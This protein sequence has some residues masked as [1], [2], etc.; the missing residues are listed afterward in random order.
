[1]RGTELVLW[2]PPKPSFRDGIRGAGHRDTG[3]THQAR[4]GLY[5]GGR[6][7]GGVGPLPK[8]LT[9]TCSKSDLSPGPLFNIAL[10]EREG[11]PTGRAAGLLGG[12]AGAA[13]SPV[14]G[15]ARVAGFAGF[16][17]TAAGSVLWLLS[18]SERPSGDPPTP[19]APEY[20]SHRLSSPAACLS[21]R[22]TSASPGSRLAPGAVR[23]DSQT[24][25]L[26]GS[27]NLGLG[28][29]RRREPM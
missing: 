17:G 12:A 3:T 6:W 22:S 8:R 2:D 5:A 26:G 28:A 9:H 11:P 10:K 16:A 14:A 25:S 15:V 4:R 29:I 19:R 18:L 1:M 24:S 21:R 23:A 27:K 7:P 13:S 20:A